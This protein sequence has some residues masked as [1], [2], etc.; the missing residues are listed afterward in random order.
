MLQPFRPRSSGLTGPALVFVLFF[1]PSLLFA[2]PQ[3]AP[4]MQA[5]T[6]EPDMN[7]RGWWMS[8]KLDS[9]NVETEA[10]WLVPPGTRF[11]GGRK[12]FPDRGEQA[13]VRGRV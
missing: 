10:S 2:E 12:Q 1:V 7:I 8:E 9:F 3:S 11:L 13:G 5:Q 6:W 4:V